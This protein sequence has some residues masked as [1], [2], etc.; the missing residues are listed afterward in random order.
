[1]KKHNTRGGR[2]YGYGKQLHYAGKQALADRYG[3]QN[4]FATQAA[5]HGRFK[6]FAV[7]C[8]EQGVRDARDINGELISRYAEELSAKVDGK[9]MSVSYAQ[10]LLSSINVA[11][12]ALRG[13]NSLKISPS[14]VV[15]ERTHIRGSIPLSYD[16]RFYSQA[17]Q[18]LSTPEAK[19]TLV[20][21]REFG[22]RLREVGLFRP[23]EALSQYQKTG[24]IDIQ[25][26]VKGGRSAPREIAISPRQAAILERASELLGRDKCLVDRYGKFT[27]WK[28][29]FYSEYQQSGA[30][31][32]IGKFHDNRAAFACEKIKELTGKEARVVNP[33]T[34]LMK[35]EEYQAKL[36]VAG[37]LGHGRVGVVSS[38]TG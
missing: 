37:M 30:R 27:A 31:E 34:T 18:K 13:D 9:E 35:Q 28:N 32:L 22:L 19:M 36:L 20:V 6:Q 11:L 1:M 2:N 10:N 12:S 3:E 7:W 5:H 33:R 23:K 38:Y 24:S 16:R 21:A 26:G 15:G 8:K 29:A 4:K 17:L 14:S 25:R